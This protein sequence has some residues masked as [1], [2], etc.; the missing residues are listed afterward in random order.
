MWSHVRL[1]IDL[2]TFIAGNDHVI[3]ELSDLC[4]MS[5]I[6]ISSPLITSLR[7][8]YRI[9]IE[10][11]CV[12]N[13]RYVTSKAKISSRFQICRIHNLSKRLQ[14]WTIAATLFRQAIIPRISES[15]P[16]AAT[17]GLL[18]KPTTTHIK[19]STQ[20][21]CDK[22][23]FKITPSVD[24]TDLVTEQT[25]LSEHEIR[26]LFN[27]IRCRRCWLQEHNLKFVFGIV[28]EGF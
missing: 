8:Q 1:C 11:F 24:T 25:N 14:N 18:L 26:F 2:L 5:Q 13:Y 15:V 20:T 4:A 23:L 22:A 7:T 16:T 17:N 10:I 21:R 19:K 12:I 9:N 6:T 28:G 3:T 27:R